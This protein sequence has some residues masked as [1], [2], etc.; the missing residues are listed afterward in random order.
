MSQAAG[1]EFYDREYHFAEDAA[2]PDEGRIWHALKRLEPMG[3]M[4]FF[5]LGCGAGWATK[6]AKEQGRAGKVVGLDFSRTALE[7]A[8]KHSPGILW[9]QGDGTA[10]PVGDKVVERL[11]C[12]GSLEHFPD[13]RR[14]LGEIAR[15]LTSGA[16]AVLIV[17]NF[18]VRTEQPQEFRTHY[19]GWKK[20]MEEAGLEVVGVGTDWGPG[21]FKNANLKR[22]AARMVGKVLCAIPFLQYQFIFSVRKR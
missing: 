16:V 1:R 18:Y 3:G 14:G 6:L 5:D 7:L 8:R 17:P 15:I 12:N 2:R 4:V 13:V 9:V 21:V 11:F 19:W 22:V 10:L 20:L